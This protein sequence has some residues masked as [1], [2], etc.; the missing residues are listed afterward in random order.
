MAVTAAG[1]AVVAVGYCINQVLRKQRGFHSPKV[2]RL[3][4]TITMAKRNNA[5]ITALLA[6]SAIT[7]LCNAT[8]DNT[9]AR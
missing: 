3:S 9:E 6:V 5:F 2:S 8:P 1:R 7:M 4:I